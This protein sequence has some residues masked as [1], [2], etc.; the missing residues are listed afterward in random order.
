M[1][2]FTGRTSVAG[3]NSKTAFSLRDLLAWVDFM[4]S[5]CMALGAEGSF[6]HG[7]QLMLLDGLGVTHPLQATKLKAD[8]L[9]FL[10]DQLPAGPG[11]QAAISTS[12]VTSEG[13]ADTSGATAAGLP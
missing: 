11:R 9:K 6:L 5:T 12:L 7:A 4:N 2:F 8:S 10:V 1:E 13:T 3:A